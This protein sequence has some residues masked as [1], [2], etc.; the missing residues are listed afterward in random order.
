MNASP[1]AEEDVGRWLALLRDG[2]EEERQLARTELGLILEARGL[3]DDAAEA[4][5]RNVADG[6]ADRRPYERLAALARAR[7]DGPAE[8]RALRALADVLAPPVPAPTPQ[9]PPP[10]AGEGEPDESA[11]AGASG[12]DVP[13]ADAPGSIV[14]PAISIAA[15]ADT[16]DVLEADT[17]AIVPAV[18]A[19]PDQPVLPHAAVDAGAA[20]PARDAGPSA[21][22][23]AAPAPPSARG[24]K[25]AD[26]DPGIALHH[27]LESHPEDA[28]HHPTHRPA[29]RA[30][31]G[32]S[33]GMVALAILVSLLVVVV[34]ARLV[35]HGVGGDD[36]EPESAAPPPTVAGPVLPPATIELR[37][38]A[39]TPSP[40][41]SPIAT[42]TP[43]PTATPSLTPTPLPPRCADAQL[44]F[45]ETG[46]P[47]EAVRAAFRD[48][49]TRQ[50]VTN[51]P[52]SSLFA[53]LGEAY[54]ARHDEVVA[55][56]VGVILQR[57]RRGL[58][59]FPLADFVAS[60]VVVAVGPGEYQLRATISPQG[61]TEM[62]SW[63]AETCEGAFMRSPA[64]ARW[65]DLMQASVGDITWALPTPRPAR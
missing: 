48:Y 18:L 63:P 43:S 27:V 56:W 23:D 29:E 64:N 50:G 53:G 49:L 16:R 31:Q 60:D 34:G 35:W 59:A 58:P 44:R 52:S 1:G 19:A 40:L 54:A 7:G 10:Q 15:D 14:M 45:P 21:E 32:L 36:V 12:L 41:P 51:D 42:R 17:A 28:H 24:R 2:S 57:E 33:R 6:V 25:H 8:A 20:Q 38:I 30:G 11:N 22:D 9:P 65:V 13:G 55:G 3:L 37:L 46:D 5:E 26:E 62:R 61:W 47:E 39:T 4:Y